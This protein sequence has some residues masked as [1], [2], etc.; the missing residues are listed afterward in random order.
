M[1]YLGFVILC[2]FFFSPR[3][4]FI[5][6]VTLGANGLLE[7]CIW[8]ASQLGLSS[9]PIRLYLVFLVAIP[10]TRKVG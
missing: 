10:T 2:S 1:F 6:F 4:G 7:T 8:T 3:F 9:A 5:C